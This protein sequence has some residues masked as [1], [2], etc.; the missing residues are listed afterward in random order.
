L[1][2]FIADPFCAEPGARLY[3][4]G[5]LA[6][7]L[8]DGQIAFVGR[9][10]E[11]V[12]IR[13]FRIEPAEIVSVLNEHPAVEASAVAAR[14]IEADDKHLVAY[15]VLQQGARPTRTEMREFAATH[16]PEHMVPSVFVTLLDLPLNHSGKVDLKLLPYPNTDN[17][18]GDEVFIPPGNP[19]EDR[20]ASIVARLLGMER[21]SVEDNF[22]LLGGRSLLGTQLIASISDN[23]GVEVPLRTLFELPTIRA[24]AAEIER[25]L[26]AKVQAMSEDD[27]QRA[28]ASLS[29]RD[30]RAM[31][32]STKAA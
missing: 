19:L 6:R 12:K 24:Q 30:R 26:T 32:L 4:T 11:Q 16:L 18:L 29:D 27:A 28:L 31:P 7:Y 17:S 22:F 1:E 13:G 3:Q 23:F 8:P 10:D 5:D 14:E 21:V 9:R 25:L 15:L 20:L 2:K